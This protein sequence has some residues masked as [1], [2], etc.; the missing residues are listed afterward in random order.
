MVEGRDS[1]KAGPLSDLELTKLCAEAMGYDDVHIAYGC[2]GTA[3]VK[4]GGRSVTQGTEFRPLKDDAQAMALVRRFEISIAWSWASQVGC[5]SK[6][7]AQRDE[8]MRHDKIACI[9]KD[10][11]RAIV[12]C[13]AKMRQQHGS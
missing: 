12:E 6:A 5:M 4:Y 13:V 9:H 2:M 8:E 11:N 7:E 10:L 1:H 3:Y